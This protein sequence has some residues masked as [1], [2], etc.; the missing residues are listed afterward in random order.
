MARSVSFPHLDRVMPPLEEISHIWAHLRQ[1]DRDYIRTFVGDIPMLA[2][3]RVDWKFLGAA[4]TFWDPVHAVFN[5][6]VS[7]SHLP[8]RN[9]ALSSEEL[10][11][12]ATSWNLTSTPPDLFWYR[13]YLGCIAD[14]IDAALASV[15]LQVVG[16]REYEV[17]LLAET[18]RSLDRVTRKTDRRLRG[19]PVLLQ[20][21]LQSH[22]NPFGLVRPVMFFTRPESIISRLLPLLLV[23]ECKVSEWIKIFR[24]IAPKGFKWRTAWMPLGPMTLKCPDFNGVPLHAF[25][26]LGSG[27]TSGFGLASGFG[28]ASGSSPAFTAS[29]FGPAFGFWPR[30]GLRPHFWASAPHRVSALLLS[31]GPVSNL[32]PALT[33]FGPWLSIYCFWAPAQHLPHSSFDTSHLL[34][35]GSSEIQNRRGFKFIQAILRGASLILSLQR[36]EVTAPKADHDPTLDRRRYQQ[37]HAFDQRMDLIHLC[38]GRR[39]NAGAICAVFFKLSFALI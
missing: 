21:W 14:H 34:L 17:A 33:A 2:M 30:I 5:I 27:L 18:I 9:I 38:C 29:G 16:G 11:P 25:T 1:V 36:P 22:A 26:A 4:E 39:L 3:C 35:S 23:E 8:S 6:Q 7:S 19:S 12:P 10:Q 15:V 31:F 28:P 32:D 20:I 13:V 24:E 37:Y